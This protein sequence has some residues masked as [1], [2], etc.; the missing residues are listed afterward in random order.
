MV[1]GGMP[2]SRWGRI[3]AASRWRRTLQTNSETP[4]QFNAGHTP[5]NAKPCC[6]QR[7][8]FRQ[9]VAGFARADVEVQRGLTRIAGLL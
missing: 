3:A 5:M 4:G 9:P 1:L 7:R 8:A 2:A 6:R